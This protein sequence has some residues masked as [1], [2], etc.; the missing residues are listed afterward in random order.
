MYNAFMYGHGKWGK[1]DTRCLSD[2][3]TVQFQQRFLRS[4]HFIWWEAV[5]KS[6]TWHGDEVTA[7]K[8]HT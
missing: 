6:K 7:G 4:W 3:T 2:S 5:S 8:A 1:N